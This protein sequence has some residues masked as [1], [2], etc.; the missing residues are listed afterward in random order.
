MLR[1]QRFLRMV[2]RDLGIEIPSS[3]LTSVRDSKMWIEVVDR[4]AELCT[5]HR[6]TLVF[7]NTRSMVER[8]CCALGERLGQDNVAAHH[9]S[10]SRALRLDAEQRLKAG[11]IQCLVATASLELGID[12]GAVDLVLQLNSTRDIAVAMQR[13]GRAGHWR[14]AIPKGR[15]FATTRDDLLEQAA[16]IRAMRLHQLDRGAGA[17]HG[18]GQ[19]DSRAVG[20]RRGVPRADGAHDRRAVSDA[21]AGDPELPPQPDVDDDRAEVLGQD[22]EPRPRGEVRVPRRDEAR[23]CD[24]CT[25]IEWWAWSR[26]GECG[27]RASRPQSWQGDDLGFGLGLAAGGGVAGDALSASGEGALDQAAVPHQ[28]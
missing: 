8:L 22:E 20:E 25:V 2:F 27:L 13:V 26:G 24:G 12:I 11:Q 18:R 10:L 21:E 15:F 7:A 14:G 9:G 3:E 6:S 1:A 4:M 28:E 23:G 16:L 19:R 17:G 5:E